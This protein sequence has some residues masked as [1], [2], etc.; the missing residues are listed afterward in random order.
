MARTKNPARRSE[1]SSDSPPSTRSPSPLSPLSPLKTPVSKTSNDSENQTQ[2]ESIPTI[3]ITQMVMEAIE[4][5]SMQTN[6]HVSTP[7][8]QILVGTIPISI[9]TI[10]PTVQ[11]TLK[12]PPTTHE[13]RSQTVTVSKASRTPKIKPST[14][15]KS[16]CVYPSKI[17]RS[18]RIASGSGKKPTIDPTIY[19]VSDSDS[20]NTLSANTPVSKHQSAK[21]SS[22]AS[23]S[24]SSEKPSSS[25]KSSSSELHSLPS[26]DSLLKESIPSHRKL[27]IP[28]IHQN[29]QVTFDEFWKDKPVAAGRTYNFAELA[30]KG[31]DLTQYTHPLGWTNFFNIKET[32]YPSLVSA[33]YFNAVVYQEEEMIIS[34]LKGVKVIVTTK[35]LSQLLDLPNEGDTLYGPSLYSMAQVNKTQLFKEMFEPG[36]DLKEPSTSKL[37]PSY[38]LLHNMCLHAV[39]PRTG[40]M[41]RV[42]DNDAMVMYHMFNK[43]RLNLPYA[44]LHHMIN[45]VESGA[46][47]KTLL[48]GMIL[49]KIFR[50]F[51]V[52]FKREEPRNTSKV[53]SIKNVMK[54]LSDFGTSSS[55]DQGVKR[56]RDEAEPAGNL[57]ILAEA[58]TSQQDQSQNVLPANSKGKEVLQEGNLSDSRDLGV[59]LEFDSTPGASLGPPIFNQTLLDGFSTIDNPVNT[60]LFSPLMTS[61]PSSFG[62]FHSTD[63]MRQWLNTAPPNLSNIHAPIFTDAGPSLPTFPQNFASL[64]SFSMT[65]SNQAAVG[66]DSENIFHFD[67]RPSKQSKFEKGVTKTRKDMG[68]IFKALTISNNNQTY[69]MKENSIL[70]TWLV[71]EFCPAMRVAPPPENP[72]I[73]PSTELPSFDDS[74]SDDSTPDAPQ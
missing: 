8:N 49:T 39:F 42:T 70:R 18:N 11:P 13:N 9:P 10:V 6:L 64:S 52:S 73:P 25:E 55:Q 14:T 32:H 4:A 19:S 20:E 30:N 69:N 5:S 23:P 21:S 43:I 2:T 35:L 61:P 16:K 29:A 59:S 41:H 3:S 31:I 7:Q 44:I 1:Y 72:E 47:K 51:N 67:P 24:S 45:V 34:N 66:L 58:V 26:D 22:S 38:K 53:F 17:R 48:Y 27:S 28:L 46:K 63:A 37:L 57:E 50:R 65:S 56:K 60:S 74:S 36:V 12:K 15:K 62:T 40:S 54:M 71:N 68:K 33:F